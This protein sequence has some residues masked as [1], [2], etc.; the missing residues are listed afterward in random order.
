MCRMNPSIA[1]PHFSLMIHSERRSE[2]IA[3]KPTF[4]TSP[5]KGCPEEPSQQPTANLTVRGRGSGRAT[6]KG[7]RYTDHLQASKPEDRGT[8]ADGQRAERLC[9]V[10]DLYF[11]H[12]PG[13]ALFHLHW[14]ANWTHILKTRSEESNGR[15]LLAEESSS[16]AKAI[17]LAL[18]YCSIAR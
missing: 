12:V 8:A 11:Q 1:E 10:E 18:S 3:Q 2:C 7:T 9:G 17:L 16:Q 5:R 14:V 6:V 4:T 13:Q 15:P